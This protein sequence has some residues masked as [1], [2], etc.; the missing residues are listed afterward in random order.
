MA[1]VKKLLLVIDL[2]H[3]L[4]TGLG[5]DPK[6]TKVPVGNE[7]S[8]RRDVNT[9]EGDVFRI[10][11]SAPNSGQLPIWHYIKVRFGVRKF[12]RKMQQYYTLAVYTNGT[13]QYALG[14]CDCLDHD[15]SLFG[16]RIIFRVDE[17]TQKYLSLAA[18]KFAWEKGDILV[19]D[20]RVDVWN[21]VKDE[22]F[23]S[24]DEQMERVIRVH[25][26]SWFDASPD[27][28][29]FLAKVRTD[30]DFKDDK[31]P[32]VQRLED[33][34]VGLY[35]KYLECGDVLGALRSCRAIIFS[36]EVFVCPTKCPDVIKEAKWFGANFIEASDSGKE[37]TRLIIPEGERAY[38]SWQYKQMEELVGKEVSKELGAVNTEMLNKVE[39]KRMGGKKQNM[40]KDIMKKRVVP[41]K[42][43]YECMVRWERLPFEEVDWKST[44]PT[45]L[46]DQQYKAPK[47]W[48]VCLPFLAEAE[49]CP[50]LS[51][52]Q[53]A[54][55]AGSGKKNEDKNDKE[56]S[57][58]RKEKTSEKQVNGSSAVGITNKKDPGHKNG[59]ST[60]DEI[61]KLETMGNGLSRP[62]TGGGERREP[63]PP[64]L[65]WVPSREREGGALLKY[66]KDLPLLHRLLLF[67]EGINITGHLR[68]ILDGR[69]TGVGT[70]MTDIHQM[71]DD[72]RS[73]K[74]RDVDLLP[75][76]KTTTGVNEVA[77]T[78]LHESEDTS[79]PVQEVTHLLLVR[80][81]KNR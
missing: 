35:Q 5:F 62:A 23:M 19:L 65:Q 10:N 8:G 60:T 53:K 54:E 61:R 71:K 52:T 72:V 29:G 45:S 7:L 22:H 41:L 47:T 1:S 78:K 27:V 67:K 6:N 25:P 32:Y 33:V 49:Y 9:G 46:E 63:P 80:A 34:C 77:T 16:D 21:K 40:V 15:Q 48:N 56:I 31:Y 2:D 20:D 18:T 58:Y 14:I 75:N 50:K 66:V 70:Q 59:S 11:I 39:L 38:D 17:S 12:L 42:W 79:N 30:G 13:E 81:K 68:E 55:E 28:S 44:P 4:I 64:P 74:M 3:T 37:V 51:D 24:V 26:F 43:V 76:I 73:T 69:H 36:G 57:Q